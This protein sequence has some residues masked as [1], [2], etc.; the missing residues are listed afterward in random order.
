M[1]DPRRPGGRA[2]P[3]LDCGWVPDEDMRR[4]A[5]YKLLA[6]Y[7]NN[8]AG[9]LAAIGGDEDGLERRELGDPAKIID[10]TLGY[11]LG[12]E[13][14]IVVPGAEH[15]DE[16]DAPTGAAEVASVQ[17]RLRDW[18]ESELL[19]MRLQQ[20]ERCAVSSGDAVYT[21]A[22]S[23]QKQRVLLRPTTRGFY[24]PEWHDGEQ[25]SAEYP[26]RVHFAWELP[27]E[28][29]RRIKA[30]LRRITYGLGP[31]GAAT[32]KARTGDGRAIR[33]DV[34]GAEGDPV[35][36]VGDTQDPVTGAVQ[37][38]YPW[39]PGTPSATTC[40][41]TE[42]EWMLED[43]KGSHDVYSLPMDKAAYRQRGDGEAL[44]RLDLMCDFIPVVHITNTIPDGGGHWGK[45]TLGT[46]LQA[47][48]ELAA[49]DT[50]SSSASA[51][52]GTPQTGGSPFGWRPGRCG[53]YLTA[54]GWPP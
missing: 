12:S 40:F 32:Q 39:A 6:A 53:S 50:D 49:T 25:D 30:R 11:L 27:P 13:Q 35:L 47:L 8:Q 20:A 19:P 1:S 9:Q 41:L 52:T 38:G 21:L 28:L 23:P 31:I 45:S 44:D 54:V 36:T 26:S 5:A 15:A 17:K 42:A 16:D 51:T 10:S 22:W 29:R 4:L 33:E 2:F 3:E 7:D 24:F 14:Q 18:A 43:L 34:I 37:R 48:D 46:V